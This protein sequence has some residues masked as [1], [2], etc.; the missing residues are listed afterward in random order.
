M[1]EQP[2]PTDD[3]RASELVAALCLATDLA[4]GFPLEHGL[5][6][7]VVAMRIADRLGVDQRTAQ[8]TYFGCLLFYA[9]CTADAEIAAETF[10]DGALLEHFTPVAFGAPSRDARVA[11]S[12]RSPARGHPPRSLW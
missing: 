12:G 3:V 8:E 5:H 11:S 9:G 6:S 4:M 1:A 7:T 10:A 2:A